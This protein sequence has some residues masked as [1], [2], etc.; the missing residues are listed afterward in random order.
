MNRKYELLAHWDG[1]FAGMG[2]RSPYDPLTPYSRRHFYFL[3]E[4]TF[5]RGGGG[6]GA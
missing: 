6:V 2:F 5:Y 4:A 3:T 1:Y